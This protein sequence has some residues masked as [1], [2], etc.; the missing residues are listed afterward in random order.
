[1]KLGLTPK[2]NTTN[3]YS[4]QHI[5]YMPMPMVGEHIIYPVSGFDERP[6]WDKGGVDW[7]GCQ[8]EYM[9]AAG[10]AAPDC[11]VPPVL[12]D[13]CDWREDV[14]FPD[15]DAWD[16]EEAKKIDHIDEIDRENNH[17]Q[18][19]LLTGLWERLH[20]LMGFENAL[21]ALLED[22]EECAAYFEAMADHK[23]RLIG[24]LHEHYKPDSILFHDDYGTQRAPFFSPETWRELVKPQLKR[25]VDYTHSLGII[26][27]LHSCGK[28][29][30]IIPDICEIGV[31]TLQCMDINDI[32]AALEKTGDKM[33]YLPSIHTQY[34][35]AQSKAGVLT[36]EEVREIAHHEFADWGASGYYAPFMFPPST[37]YEEV[38]VDEFNKVREELAGTYA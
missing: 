26:F 38:V 16:W 23:I 18:L 29:D 14:H 7:F 15:L 30:D 33:S 13:I 1:M 36:E 5:D 3:F 31:D 21:C 37:W 12:A 22:P 10:A 11:N 19:V 17:V 35:E 25:I 32:G 27:M 8:W 4:H 9:E 24:K 34:F 6:K 2:Q 28:Y 20:C